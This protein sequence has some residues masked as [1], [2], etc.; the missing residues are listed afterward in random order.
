[1]FTPVFLYVLVAVY[2]GAVNVYGILILKFQKESR[3][4][5]DEETAISDFKLMFTALIGG[6]TGIYV[7]MF[8]MKYRLKSILLM[9]GL[10]VLITVNVYLTILAFTQGF[11]LIG[12]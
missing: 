1:M 5:G 8:I 7:F 12:I 9:V 10:P 2:L 11:S 6:A 4:S 3:E